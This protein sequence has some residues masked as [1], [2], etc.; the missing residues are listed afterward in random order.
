MKRYTTIVLAAAALVAAGCKDNP[1]AN[2]ID[3]PTVDAL[4]GALTRVTLQQLATGVLAQDRAS[5]NA[6]AYLFEP[7]IFARDVYRIDASEPRYVQE[8][9]GGNPDPGSFTGGG[10]WAGYYTAIRA[11][12]NLILALPPTA[13]TA[14]T[15]A[16]INAT[17]GFFRTMKALDYWRVIEMHDSVG[18]TIQ[19]DDASAVTDV[20]CKATV[21]SYIAALLDSA[22]ADFTAAGGTTK[23]PFKLPSGFTAFGRDHSVVSNL[24][25]FN[26]GIKGKVDFYRGLDRTNPTPALFATAITE[27]TQALGGAAAGA[28][29]KLFS[30]E[31]GMEILSHVV[32][33]GAVSVEREVTWEEIA[34][35]CGRD[36]VVLNCADAGVEQR[37]KA[38]VE[39]AIEARDAGHVQQAITMLQ[40][41]LAD[42]PEYEPA[43]NELTRLHS[44]RGR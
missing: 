36:E 23:L 25:R 10:A 20:K 6:F 17:R 19:T 16:E 22:N 11:G 5:S 37:M 29:A 32:A 28:V 1:V 24:V 7:G 21:L 43:K 30:R 34:G 40:Q 38:E 33:V 31:L 2:P 8:T 4:S 9:L 26:R 13:T 12:N 14:F 39:K 3:A 42:E 44:D 35:L 41:L 15:T 27:L 18:A